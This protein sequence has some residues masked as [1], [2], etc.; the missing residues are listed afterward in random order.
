M[1]VVIGTED[2]QERWVESFSPMTVI[3]ALVLLCSLS[4]VE[5]KL[6]CLLQYIVD[7]AGNHGI[8]TC[9]SLRFILAG[10]GQVC[11]H[12]Q[13]ATEIILTILYMIYFETIL[14]LW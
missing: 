4:D 11:Q 6:A 13:T 7:K 9:I 14:W 10:G 12:S 5:I 1:C 2:S 8:F 3:L